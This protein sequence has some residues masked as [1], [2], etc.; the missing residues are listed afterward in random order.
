MSELS[1]LVTAAKRSA[2]G[3]FAAT[4]A[5]TVELLAEDMGVRLT[6]ALACA[7]ADAAMGAM[8]EAAGLADLACL[9]GLIGHPEDN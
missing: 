4:L 3:D 8:F 7:M 6:P 5:A 9:A 1:R 2:D